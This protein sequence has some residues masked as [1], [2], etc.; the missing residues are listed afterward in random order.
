M[1]DWRQDLFWG[2]WSPIFSL[3][4]ASRHDPNDV[5]NLKLTPG[6]PPL[7]RGPGLSPEISRWT[8]TRL[9]PTSSAVGEL[10]SPSPP[11]R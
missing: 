7:R 8:W 10:S 5:A 3:L 6:F 4:C 1:D 9:P 11:A 2:S